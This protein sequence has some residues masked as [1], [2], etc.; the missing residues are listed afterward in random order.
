MKFISY[1]TLLLSL[2]LLCPML[3]H[4]QANDSLKILWIG[5]S[6]TFY[7]DLPALVTKLAAEQGMKL[8]PTRFLKGGAHLAGHYQNSELIAALQKG[9]WDY[10][11]MQ[12]HSSA[13]AQSTR[14]VI[15]ETYYYAHLL[16]S[17]AMKGSPKAHVIFY[18]TWGHKNGNM[19]NQKHPDP[20]YPLDETYEDFQSRLQTTYLELTYENKAWCSPV[21][22]AWRQV[23]QKHPEIE[24]YKKD[25]SH[26]SFE[27]SYLAAHCFLSTILQRPYASRMYFDLPE[28]K[29]MILQQTAQNA[30]FSNMKLLGLKK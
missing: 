13:P 11:V 8:A 9:G 27:G 15:A 4:A 16:D 26:P 25:C 23:R 21:G 1:K 29:A 3:T 18:M 24:L 14:D 30:V 12:E 20:A 17:I 19:Q 7:N 10:I 6:Y 5:N 28:D 22:I 2:A